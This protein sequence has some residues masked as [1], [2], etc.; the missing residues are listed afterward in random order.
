MASYNNVAKIVYMGKDDENNV[1][2]FGDCYGDDERD[3]II[4][5]WGEAVLPRALAMFKDYETTDDKALFLLDVGVEHGISNEMRDYVVEFFRA[6]R[7]DDTQ[8]VYPAVKASNL[9]EYRYLD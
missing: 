3:I 4:D 5:L 9:E 8:A 2:P 6:N 7:G 1:V